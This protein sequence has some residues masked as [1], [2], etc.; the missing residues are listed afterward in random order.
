MDSNTHVTLQ[1]SASNGDLIFEAGGANEKM[2]VRQ[3][4]RVGIGVSSPSFF[5]DIV[6]DKA[7]LLHHLTE[8]SI[9]TAI[10]GI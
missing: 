2:R 3:N 7:I 9:L 4:G 5:L 8:A 6:S 10:F 1:A